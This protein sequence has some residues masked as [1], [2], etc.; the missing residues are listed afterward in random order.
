MFVIS[1]VPAVPG[2]PVMP[3]VPPAVIEPARPPMPAALAVAVLY[4]VAGSVGKSGKRRG[5]SSSESV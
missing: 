2:V 5:C 1:V 3:A 4:S